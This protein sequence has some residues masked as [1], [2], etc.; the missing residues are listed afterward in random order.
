M[1][2]LG[3]DNASSG[4][5]SLRQ[6]MATPDHDD[7]VQLDI[8]KG[9]PQLLPSQT[10]QPSTIAPQPRRQVNKQSTEY[11]IKTGIAGGLAG[12]AV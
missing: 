1:P 6:N 3:G 11:I 5:H 2:S 7:P 4:T 8:S 12:C 10:P 9:R